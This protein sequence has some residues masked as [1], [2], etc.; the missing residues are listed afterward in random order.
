MTIHSTG[1]ISFQDLV[2]EFSTNKPLSLSEMY[3]GAGYV[4]ASTGV[5]NSGAISLGDFYGASA[6]SA[7]TL[8]YNI[9]ADTY[10]ISSSTILSDSSWDRVSPVIL[11]IF[12][13]SRA[14]VSS[15]KAIGPAIAINALPAGSRVIINNNG[16]I[17]GMGGRGG[18]IQ[19]FSA[20]P[21]Q[22]GGDAIQIA[23]GVP[24]SINNLGTIAGGGGGGGALSTSKLYGGGGGQ[25][26]LLASIGGNAATASGNPGTLSGPGAGGGP[27]AGMGGTWGNAGDNASSLGGAGGNAVVG[28]SNVTWISAGTIH[29]AL[30]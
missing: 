24:V 28:N 2:D 11:T 7:Y 17:I 19:L 6:V 21:G 10:S 14:T 29:G 18:D 20:M 8:T 16:R 5:P 30:I 9:P 13:H 22:Q 27:G 26:G 4:P 1:P 15:T 25:S 23:S 3:A 12:I